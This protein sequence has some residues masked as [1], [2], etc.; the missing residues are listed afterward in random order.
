MTAVIVAATLGLG[1][2]VGHSR[3]QPVRVQLVFWFANS[4]RRLM[5]SPGGMQM[6]A[7]AGRVMLAGRKTNH[8]GDGGQSNVAFAAAAAANNSI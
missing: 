2:V 5:A 7:T 3:L 1:F 6:R 4:V 8:I